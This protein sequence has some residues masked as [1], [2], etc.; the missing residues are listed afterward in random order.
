M[1]KEE[2]VLLLC[3]HRMSRAF[4]LARASTSSASIF[5]RQQDGLGFEFRGFGAHGEHIWYQI[6]ILSNIMY[7]YIAPT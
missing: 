1:P 4:F 6:P 3:D 7:P 5:E 2:L